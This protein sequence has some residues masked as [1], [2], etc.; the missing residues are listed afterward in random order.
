MDL[1]NLAADVG[2]CGERV[3]A[4]DKNFSYYAHLSIYD[5]ARPFAAGR[6]VLDAGC[7]TGYGSF[8]L[9]SY[10]ASEVTAV[11]ASPTFATGGSD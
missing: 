9:A 1:P 8:F 7:G 10:G 5:F 2:N 6:H 11:D 4:D 3:V